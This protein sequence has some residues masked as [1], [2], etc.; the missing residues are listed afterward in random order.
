MR[1]VFLLLLLAG[2]AGV[3]PAYQLAKAEVVKIDDG[4]MAGF[5]EFIC[6]A[7]PIAAWYRHFG[8]KREIWAA[9]CDK[10]VVAPPERSPDG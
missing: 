4:I 5:Q 7:M 2:C 10:K 9:F 6:E 8:D 3:G 1:A